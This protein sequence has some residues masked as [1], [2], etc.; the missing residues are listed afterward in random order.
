MQRKFRI[1]ATLTTMILLSISGG[2]AQ[3]DSFMINARKSI[4]KAEK[5]KALRTTEENKLEGTLL[6]IL[7]L[8]EQQ[9]TSE[10]KRAQLSQLM[11]AMISQK[12]LHVDS[13]GR[14]RVVIDLKSLSDTTEVKEL[15]RSSG[16]EIKDVGLVPFISCFIHPA[17][18]DNLVALPSVLL[19]REP[20]RGRHRVT[21]LSRQL[22]QS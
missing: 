19:V 7:R 1:I 6:H 10:T 8:A 21:R 12:L 2:S 3:V 14:I 13:Q 18:L 17:K 22:V 20:M 16:G 9:D 5:E 4:E 11:N 15:I